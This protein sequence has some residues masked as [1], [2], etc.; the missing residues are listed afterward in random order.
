MAVGVGA[1]VAAGIVT[2]A[3]PESNHV[4]LCPLKAA[5][6]FDCP[7]CGCLRAV[8]DVV[9]GDVYG[10]ADHNV[11]FVVA[12]PVVAVLWSMWVVRSR[13]GSGRPLVAPGWTVGALLMVV[14]TFG[15]VRNLPGLEWLASS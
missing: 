3:N 12:L 6:G 13:A 10:A 15:V 1:L 4:P 11:L 5:T 9:S 7:F 2:V 14:M 8:Q